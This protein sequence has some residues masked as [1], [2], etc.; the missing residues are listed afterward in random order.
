MEIL[1]NINTIISIM[2]GVGSVIMF[3]CAKKE[4]EECISIKNEIITQQQGKQANDIKG[5]KNMVSND[6]YNIEKVE[7][8]DNRK[9]I[10]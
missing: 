7:T 3:L 10:R 5:N 6:N 2:A 9:S 8:F 4:K 1:E